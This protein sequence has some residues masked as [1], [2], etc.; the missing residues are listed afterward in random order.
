LPG[1]KKDTQQAQ[2]TVAGIL[3]VFSV[4]VAPAYLRER[5]SDRIGSIDL[6]VKGKNLTAGCVEASSFQE[7]AAMVSKG[8]LHSQ[9]DDGWAERVRW[10]D[11]RLQLVIFILAEHDPS[12]LPCML[13][14]I[15]SE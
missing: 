14:Y 11:N 5:Q 7:K 3:P 1:E 12:N 15:G 13:A 10:V 9:Q 8:P 2:K 6:D 4:M